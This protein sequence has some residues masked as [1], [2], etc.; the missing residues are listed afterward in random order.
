MKFCWSLVPCNTMSPWYKSNLDLTIQFALSWVNLVALI[1]PVRLTTTKRQDIM[2]GPYK[3]PIS[4]TCTLPYMMSN[5]KTTGE[6]GLSV[7]IA[8]SVLC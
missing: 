2:I 4:G 8:L 6:E 1:K 5:G 7:Q 3:R